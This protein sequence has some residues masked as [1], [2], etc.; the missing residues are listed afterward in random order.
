MEDPPLVQIVRRY[1]ERLK[2]EEIIGV[3]VVQ[4]LTALFEKGKLTSHAEIDKVLD[5]SEG[6]PDEDPRAED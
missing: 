3:E 5:P 2:S 6:E 4:G 1:F